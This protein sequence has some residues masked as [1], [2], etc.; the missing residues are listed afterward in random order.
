MPGVA[1]REPDRIRLEYSRRK[2]GI[3]TDQNKVKKE[4]PKLE[5]LFL[6]FLG[7][8]DPFEC[9]LFCAPVSVLSLSWIC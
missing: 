1:V 8:S 3:L 9:F 4:A 5:R 7:S 2:E 6:S